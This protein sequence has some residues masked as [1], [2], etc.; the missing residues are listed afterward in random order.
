MDQNDLRPYA[1]AHILLRQRMCNKY[2]GE[3]IDM[4]VIRVDDSKEKP[5]KEPGKSA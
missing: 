3:P 5:D 2:G 4:T 1:K